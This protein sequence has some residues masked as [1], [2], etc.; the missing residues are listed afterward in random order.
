MSVVITGIGAVT[1]YGVGSGALGTGF[2]NGLTALSDSAGSLRGS[3]PDFDFKDHLGQRGLRGID[4][5][6]RLTLLACQEALGAAGLEATA[7]DVGVVLGTAFS[8]LSSI[9]GFFWECLT[10]G[11]RMV[12]ASNFGNIVMNA[13]A[14]QVALRHGFTA[15]NATLTAGGA[16]GV[17]ALAWG[18][19]LLT[20]GR[21][22]S[23]LAGGVDVLSPDVLA[24]MAAQGLLSTGF[25]PGEAAVMMVLER[26][27]DARARGARVLARLAGHMSAYDPGRLLGAAPDAAI[28][29]R[30]MAGALAQ[31]GSSP[32]DLDLVLTNAPADTALDAAEA[33]ALA[34]LL[35]GVPTLAPKALVGDTLGAAGALSAAVATLRLAESGGPWQTDSGGPRQT[36]SGG[37]RQILVNAFGPSGHHASLVLVRSEDT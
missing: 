24:I 28:A 4:R 23:V 8:G 17:D 31:A 3:I 6:G 14:S 26:E 21:A 20:A 22:R 16:S 5:V 13:A 25:V 19:D 27:D 35:P 32:A 12:T 34:A 18:R 29:R 15:L 1:P 7:D 37:P 36:E 2:S 33:T 10:E 11:P 30:V 9:T